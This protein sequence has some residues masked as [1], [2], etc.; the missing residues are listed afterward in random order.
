MKKRVFVGIP[1]NRKLAGK[2]LIWT[3]KYL[4]NENIRVIS[5]ENL[6]ITLVPP[7][8]ENDTLS[9][10][11]KLKSINLSEFTIHLTDIEYGPSN[12]NPRLI[13]A[14][15]KSPRKLLN[16]LNELQNSFNYKKTQREHVLHLTIARFN[17]ND[18]PKFKQKKIDKR[19]N[20]RQSVNSMCLYESKLSP[21]GARYSILYKI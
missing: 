9:V 11:K 5:P 17:K 13:W 10:I 14:K 8:Y 6:H 20:W 2:I 7:W 19:V 21:K 4:N 1:I 15:G 16:I 3:R 18:F 12:R